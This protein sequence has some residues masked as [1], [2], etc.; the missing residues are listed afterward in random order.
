MSMTSS[1]ST[2]SAANATMRKF[3]YPD[4]VVAEYTHWVVQ[5][6]PRQ[7]TLGAL[8]LICKA[9]ARAFHAIGAAA[10][11]ELERVT[12]DIEATLAGL[13][14]YERINYLML[15]MVDPDVHFHVIPRY[16]G[17]RRLEAIE[18]ADPGWPGPPD[19]KGGIDADTS[20]RNALVTAFRGAWPSA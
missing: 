16:S 18:L 11:H 1:V 5:L 12:T 20:L 9:D 17:T 2:A 4:S 10:F 13:V 14:A 6:R 19:L 3:G 8:V 15:M 7:V